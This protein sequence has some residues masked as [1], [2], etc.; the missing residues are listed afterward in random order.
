MLPIQC[1]SFIPIWNLRR[2]QCHVPD[3]HTCSCGPAVWHWARFQLWIQ[4]GHLLWYGR[5]Q[6]CGSP[7]QIFQFLHQGG[8]SIKDLRVIISECLS[9][10]RRTTLQCLDS[11]K[12]FVVVICF[13]EV[14]SF[15]SCASGIHSEKA[16]V[17]LNILAWLRVSLISTKASIFTKTQKP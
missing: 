12:N 9:W 1:I 6:H 15:E 2:H 11:A 8:L 17:A 7:R 5:H 4:P 14:S 3:Q 10:L 16:W 13:T